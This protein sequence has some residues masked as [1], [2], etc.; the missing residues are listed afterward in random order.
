MHDRRRMACR[1]CDRG[2]PDSAL[3][4]ATGGAERP[5]LAPVRS[6]RAHGR[7]GA[8]VARGRQ[9]ASSLLAEGRRRGSPDRVVA[10]RQSSGRGPS[11][12]VSATRPLPHGSRTRRGP[13][14]FVVQEADREADLPAQHPAARQAARLPAPHVDAGRPRRAAE[15]PAQGSP[16]AVGLIW[17]VRDRQT[18]VDFR[19]SRRSRPLRDA[20]ADPRRRRP[21]TWPRRRGWPSPS[22]AGWARRWSATRSVVGC[23]PSFATAAAERRLLP[24]AYLAVVRPDGRCQ[25][26]SPSSQQM[27]QH[28]WTGLSAMA[29]VAS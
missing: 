22:A 16:A 17:R 12:A 7:S 9:P 24:G 20:D 14:G 10:G 29:E 26:R 25:P 21:A 3:A 2:V 11:G 4:T 8:P 5:T 15:S 19:R 23:G 18:F 27:W 28:R 1:N 6:P 13:G